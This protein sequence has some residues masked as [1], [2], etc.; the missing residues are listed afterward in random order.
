[1]PDPRARAGK[2]APRSRGRNAIAPEDALVQ[3]SAHPD[4]THRNGSRS[5]A[6]TDRASRN[7]GRC[8]RRSDAKTVRYPVFVEHGMD[9]AKHIAPGRLSHQACAKCG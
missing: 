6:P 8:S 3:S 5:A 7:P 4:P 9:R 2:L 1:M